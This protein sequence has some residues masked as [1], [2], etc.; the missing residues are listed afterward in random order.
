MPTAWEVTKIPDG[1]VSL[2]NLFERDQPNVLISRLHVIVRVKLPRSVLE[3][4]SHVE[5]RV[6][7]LDNEPRSEHC[8]VALII[9]GPTHTS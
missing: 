9:E 6:F 4:V 8:D 1:L 7:L 3:I 5:D 2:V